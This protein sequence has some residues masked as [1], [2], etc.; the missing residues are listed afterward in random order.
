MNSTRQQPEDEHMRAH[1]R[2]TADSKAS[3]WLTVELC[4]AK[5][6]SGNRRYRA[7]ISARSERTAERLLEAYPHCKHKKQQC[8]VIKFA[9]LGPHAESISRTLTLEFEFTHIAIDIDHDQDL[10]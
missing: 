3:A 5:H 7:P 6:D 4:A 10:I 1:R 8:I 9:G 2:A